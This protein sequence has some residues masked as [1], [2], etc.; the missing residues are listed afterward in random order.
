MGLKRLDHAV[1]NVHKL[2]EALAYIMG[3]TGVTLC[4]FAYDCCSVLVWLLL[5]FVWPLVL[6]PLVVLRASV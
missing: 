1:G 5:L 3:F 4:V 2:G 6:L